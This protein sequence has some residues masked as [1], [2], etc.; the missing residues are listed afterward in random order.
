[1]SALNARV[2]RSHPKPC[3]MCAGS[4]RFEPV[5][6]WVPMTHSTFALS[7]PCIY[8]DGSGRYMDAVSK[9]PVLIRAQ[10]ARR[11]DAPIPPPLR[12]SAPL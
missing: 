2:G 12:P 3:P 1:M 8:C 9:L 10:L 11:P 6:E 7:V 4:G 5:V